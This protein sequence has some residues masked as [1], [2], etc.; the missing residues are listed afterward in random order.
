MT[1][2]DSSSANHDEAANLPPSLSDA[3]PLTGQVPYE[4]EP[5]PSLLEWPSDRLVPLSSLPS[6]EQVPPVP[7]HG[8]YGRTRQRLESFRR[9]RTAAVTVIA[10][11]AVL[12]LLVHANPM[13]IFHRIAPQ[14][15]S[16]PVG[17]VRGARTA[18]PT[19]A[20]VSSTFTPTPAPATQSTGLASSQSMHASPRSTPSAVQDHCIGGSSFSTECAW[21]VTVSSET[22]ISLTVSPTSPTAYTMTVET[23]S[24]HLLGRYSSS[25]A[26]IGIRIAYPPGQLYVV[27]S[28]ATPPPHGFTIS[29]S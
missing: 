5:V 3:P 17:S 14:K 23:T 16:T 25:G 28:P 24:G 9:F 18:P 11:A 26:S 7:G 13:S 2:N 29:A 6:A 27:I 21:S 1:A 12:T 4:R 10:G 8:N 19:V 22:Y 15:T 20:P